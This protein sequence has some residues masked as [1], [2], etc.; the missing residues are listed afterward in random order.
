M[1][2][3][4]VVEGKGQ[5]LPRAL[6]LSVL[7]FCVDLGAILRFKIPHLNPTARL[8]CQN[9]LNAE[10]FGQLFIRQ[11]DIDVAYEFILFWSGLQV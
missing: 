9:L 7:N 10:L 5:D 4:T 8:Y 2:Q 3:E 6:L 11:S 1:K